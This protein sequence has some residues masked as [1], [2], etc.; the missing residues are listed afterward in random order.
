MRVCRVACVLMALGRL[1]PSGHSTHVTQDRG[2]G[3][4]PE[5]DGFSSSE[6]GH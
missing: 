1:F 4:S 2:D 3:C 5:W 6:S